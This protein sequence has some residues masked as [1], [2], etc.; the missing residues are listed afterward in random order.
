MKKLITILGLIGITGCME[1]HIASREN[2]I[3]VELYSNG[4]LVRRIENVERAV[5]VKSLSGEGDYLFIKERDGNS[6]NWR[7][8]PYLIEN[9]S[10]NSS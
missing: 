8:G 3:S 4:T 7:N 10:C 2:C 9:T 6:Y 1:S 5:P